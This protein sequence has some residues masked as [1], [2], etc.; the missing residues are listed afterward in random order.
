MWFSLSKPM[1]ETVH[2]VTKIMSATSYADIW[3]DG[4]DF[5]PSF[6]FFI[7]AQRRL[8]SVVDRMDCVD[9]VLLLR[10]LDLA[11]AH[12]PTLLVVPLLPFGRLGRD[13]EVAYC[14]HD[15]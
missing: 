8:I 14:H 3:I 10:R 15:R 7:Y 5:F 9:S 11:L 1:E 2:V 13:V 12:D 6:F 4:G